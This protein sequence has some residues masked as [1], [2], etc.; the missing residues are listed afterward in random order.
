[1]PKLTPVAREKFERCITCTCCP[2]HQMNRPKKNCPLSQVLVSEIYWWYTP[3]KKDK[4]CTCDCRH[5]VRNIC[6]QQDS[7]QW[8][9]DLD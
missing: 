4:L 5:F 1:M 9:E 8:Q 3:Q 6:R 7:I 2:R